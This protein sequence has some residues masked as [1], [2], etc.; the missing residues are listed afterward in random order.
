MLNLLMLSQLTL[1]GFL[2]RFL[3]ARLPGREARY[4][5][6]EVTGQRHGGQGGKMDTKMDA[7]MDRMNARIDKMNLRM[8]ATMER[9]EGRLEGSRFDTTFMCSRTETR[10]WSDC[11]E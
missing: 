2:A 11:F 6:L 3:L 1:L 9:Q 10:P 7:K 4:Q 8:N 5:R